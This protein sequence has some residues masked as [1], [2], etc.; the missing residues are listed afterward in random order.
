MSSWWEEIIS[1]LKITGNTPDLREYI[2]RYEDETGIIHVKKGMLQAVFEHDADT[3]KL[4]FE[5]QTKVDNELRE[6]T[7]RNSLP[8]NATHVIG[9]LSMLNHILLSRETSAYFFLKKLLKDFDVQGSD[10]ET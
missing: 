5:H 8:K 10:K 4:L 1:E 6:Y 3:T 2:K 9:E 7:R